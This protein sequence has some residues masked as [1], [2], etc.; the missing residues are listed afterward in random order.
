MRAG[1]HVETI[2][3]VWSWILDPCHLCHVLTDGSA[4][5]EPIMGHFDV[6]W[7]GGHLGVLDDDPAISEN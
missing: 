7:P 5:L 1:P 6:A 4:L 3:V 2:P